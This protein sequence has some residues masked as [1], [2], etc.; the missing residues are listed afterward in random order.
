MKFEGVT[1]YK[2]QF[3]EPPKVES[4]PP[5]EQTYKKINIPFAGES[6]YK[7]QYPEYKL[8]PM[9]FKSEE[10]MSSPRKPPAVKF[11]GHTSYHDQ[12]KGYTI[13]LPKQV[14]ADHQ[15]YVEKIHVPPMNYIN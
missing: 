2:T 7:N 10:L 15:C 4:R 14:P 1:S 11:E 8:E 9:S 5:P 12:F 13:D 6:S 3:Q